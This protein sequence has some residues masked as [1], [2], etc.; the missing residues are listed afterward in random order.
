MRSTRHP[1]TP[2]TARFVLWR[3]VAAAYVA[4]A[5][6]AGF[7]GLVSGQPSLLVQAAT[8][9]GVSSAVVA[10]LIGSWLRRRG[11]R[12]RWLSSASRP[13]VIATVA[14]GA[15]LAGGL[16]GWLVNIGASAWIAAHHWPWPGQLGIDLPV[17]AA[18]A[19]TIITWRWR[20]AQQAPASA[21]APATRAVTRPVSS[22]E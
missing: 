17:S 20:C 5:L 4:P 18:I 12:H 6:I 8:S 13:L 21:V 7:G 11:Q 22:P 15:A 19:A 10:A 3:E 2:G 9:I 14:S 16:A 1:A